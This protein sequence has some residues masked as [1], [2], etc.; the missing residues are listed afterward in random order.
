M[1]IIEFNSEPPGRARGPAC[2]TCKG[3]TRL[4]GIE[5]HLTAAHKDLHTYQCMACD[6]VHAT[7][8]PLAN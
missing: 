4:I 3:P 5:P 1:S 6:A 8:V 7:V 2:E